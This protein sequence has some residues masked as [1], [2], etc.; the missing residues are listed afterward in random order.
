MTKEDEFSYNDFEL[1]TTIGTGTF[2]RVFLSRVKPSAFAKTKL[3]P[4]QYYALKVLQKTN[5]VKLRQVE[6]VQNEKN[7]LQQLESPFVVNLLY[8]FQ[9]TANLYMVMDYVPGGELFSHLRKR[10]KFSLSMTLF[11][12]S[13]LTAAIG[14]MHSQGVIYRDLKPENLLLTSRGHLKLCDFGFAKYV[15]EG[16]ITYTLCGTAEYL[17]PEII[18]GKG[19]GK[20]VDWYALGILIFEMLVG[21][22]PFYD[23]HPFGIYEKILK[24]KL[25][26]PSS[27]NPVAKDLVKHLLQHDLSKRL[28]NLR[29]GTKGVKNHMFFESIDWE[30]VNN[31]QSTPP[32]IPKL[33]HPGDTRYF[34]VYPEEDTTHSIKEDSFQHL[35]EDF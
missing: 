35:F 14:F 15:K 29:N 23:D 20:A 7:V 9:S 10:G 21:Y 34:D 8:H 22:P 30:K 1:M 2:G 17:A 6:H 11:Y 24:A 5:I 13:E 12:A 3:S 33:A 28:G 4:F 26:F 25:I 31:L 16:D 32:I 19:H 18:K 27:I